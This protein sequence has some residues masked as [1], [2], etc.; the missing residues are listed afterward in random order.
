MSTFGPHSTGGEALNRYVEL[1]LGVI[2]TDGSW[3]EDHQALADHLGR[4]A[5]AWVN[6]RYGLGLSEDR[7]A[8]MGDTGAPEPNQMER[9][10]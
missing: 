8:A 6:A 4:E 2:R 5:A 9:R 7:A 1:A 10:A 3:S